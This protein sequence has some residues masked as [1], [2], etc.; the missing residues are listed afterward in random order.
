MDIIQVLHKHRL[1][2]TKRIH[3]IPIQASVEEIAILAKLLTNRYVGQLENSEH[4]W[5]KKHAAHTR[6]EQQYFISTQ[7]LSISVNTCIFLSLLLRI[8]PDWLEQ[9]I[10]LRT[11]G[12]WVLLEWNKAN[13]SVLK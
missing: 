5:L 2:E 9:E 7:E 4:Q 10:T 11:A 6:A 1:Q 13:D 3:N 8:N 12:S